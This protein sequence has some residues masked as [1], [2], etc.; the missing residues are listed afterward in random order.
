MKKQPNIEFDEL[1]QEIHDSFH[2]KIRRKKIRVLVFGPDLND[3]KPS[4]ELRKYI[5]NKCKEDDYTVVLAEHEEIKQLYE[6]IFRSAND[7]CKMEYHLARGAVRGRDIIDGIVIIPDSVGSFIE[8]G[9]FTIDDTLHNKILV[10]FNKEH[11]SNMANNFIGL[12]AK[13][14]F[15]NGNARTRLLDY[16]NNEVAWSEVSGFLDF[17]K[18]LKIWRMWKRQK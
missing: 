6:K 7:L 13:S 4:A 8:L 12:G 9:M 3:D 1:F 10:L 18:G 11:A 15:D 14:A 17:R 2:P 5:I 16:N